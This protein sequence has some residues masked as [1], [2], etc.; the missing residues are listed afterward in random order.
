MPPIKIFLS[1]SHRDKRVADALSALLH[2][3]FTPEFV[4]VSYSSDRTAGAGI[5]AGEDWLPWIMREVASSS[6]CI[7]MLTPESL[8]KP[9]LMWEAGA[10]GGVAIAKGLGAEDGGGAGQPARVTTPVVPLLY[11]ISNDQVPGPLRSKQAEFGD[12]G[13]GILRVLE[14]VHAR[15][16]GLSKWFFDLAVKPALP[17]YLEAVKEALR[18]RPMALS[19]AAVQEWCERLDDLRKE[20]RFAEVRPMHQ[21]ML[22][23]FSPADQKEPAP[24][25]LRLHRRLGDMY[26]AGKDG[27]HAAI[28]FELALR[29]VPNDPFLQHRRALAELEAGNAGAAREQLERAEQAD[30]TI[31]SWNPEFAGLK[32]R[33][34]REQWL[35]TRAPEDLRKARDAYWQAM[36]QQPDSY[37]L[38][39]NAGQLS[40]AL[41]EQEQAK[42]AFRRALAAI[43][44]LKERSVWSLATMATASFGLGETENGLRHLRELAGFQPKPTARQVRSIVD[45]LARMRDTLGVEKEAFESWLTALEGARGDAAAA[46]PAAP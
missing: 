5:E 32:G 9:W 29:L 35:R 10:V 39:D 13:D 19:E 33:I 3:V 31:A 16:N 4:T 20:N 17:L 37:Y 11:R 24:L 28:E 14:M 8:S 38:A 45:G 34:W 1:H 36:D 7:V 18:A 12:S 22:R 30:P 25:D 23:V 2:G 46:R 6:V 27:A 21:A 44:R 42:E 15:V 41:G 26:L 40:L 43:E